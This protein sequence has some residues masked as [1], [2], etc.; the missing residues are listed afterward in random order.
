MSGKRLDVLPC[1]RLA[2][3]RQCAPTHGVQ[4]YE[5]LAIPALSALHLL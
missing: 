2:M 1:F 5:K 4:Q 3:R